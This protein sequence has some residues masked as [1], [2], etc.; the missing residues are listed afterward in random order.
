M[1][2]PAFAAEAP[3]T[4]ESAGIGT[5][6]VFAGAAE[7]GMETFICPNCGKRITAGRHGQVALN[8]KC[9]YC[10]TLC[11]R[12][13][14]R[15]PF[16][17]GADAGFFGKYVSRGVTLSD[18]PVFQP[19]VWVSYMNLTVSVWGNMDLTD[20]NGD[21]GDFNELDFTAGYSWNWGRLNMEAGGIY[22]VFPGTG[23]D[24]TAELYAGINYDTILQPTVTVFYDFLEADGFYGTLSV[25]HSFGLPEV[26]GLEPSLDLSAQV[27]WGTKE[28]NEFNSGTYHT[29]F[30]DAVFTAGLPVTVTDNISVAP[31]LSYST[32]LDRTIRSKN[33]HND[34]VVWGVILSASM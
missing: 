26:L 15:K 19:D 10:G 17:F 34:N 1:C 27:G 6:D 13:E 16:C 24:D 12:E 14:E 22:Y 33:P 31:T 3:I 25:G 20:Y 30:T 9:P 7:D 2:A 32:V 21:A 11:T 23:S 5:E 28:F 29:T 18:D 4:D 8:V